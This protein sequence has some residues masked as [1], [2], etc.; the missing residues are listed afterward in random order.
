MEKAQVI[1]TLLFVAG[2]NTLLQ[3]LVGTRLPVVMGGSYAFIIP[4]IAASHHSRFYRYEFNPHQV[5]LAQP[6]FPFVFFPLL[7]NCHNENG[8]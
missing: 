8:C 3:T 7:V 6:I 5:G 2:I 1:E 4:A